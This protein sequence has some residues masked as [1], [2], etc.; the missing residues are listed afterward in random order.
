MIGG[1]VGINFAKQVF[2]EPTPL[3]VPVG[4][5]APGSRYQIVVVPSGGQRFHINI[6]NPD[7]II[8]HLSARFDESAVV[9]NSMSDGAWHSEDRFE[10]PF[11][12]NKVYTLDFISKGGIIE[13]NI[14]GVHFTDF[15]ERIPSHN[16]NLIE[17]EG[18]VHVH[19]VHIFH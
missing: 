13:I 15:V 18:D 17:V 3:A 11:Q 10:L 2:N 6:R 7:G 19:A 14:N 12:P 1:G 5:F 4:G 9:N 16:A 8:L